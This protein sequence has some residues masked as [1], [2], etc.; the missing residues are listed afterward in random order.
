MANHCH[1]DYLH[2]S[3]APWLLLPVYCH[4]RDAHLVTEFESAVVVLWANGR[5]SRS[6]WCRVINSR[7]SSRAIKSKVFIQSHY[8]TNRRPLSNVNTF[9]FYG[10]AGTGAEETHTLVG[11][12]VHSLQ[13]SEQRCPSWTRGLRRLGSSRFRRHVRD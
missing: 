3:R 2:M 9:I 4:L 11:G 5:V 13:K 8:P 7:N 10:P 6:S 1:V 12:G